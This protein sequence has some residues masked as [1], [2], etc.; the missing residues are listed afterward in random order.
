MAG[1]VP[2]VA[3]RAA[4][5]LIAPVGRLANLVTGWLMVLLARLGPVRRQRLAKGVARL[6]YGLGIRRRVT[7]DNLRQAF[8]EKDGTE[9]ERIARG[10]YA[11]MAITV[12]EAIAAS[13]PDG[14]VATAEVPVVTENWGLVEEAIA[15]KQGFLVA[16][17]HFGNWELLGEIMARRGIPIN[18]VVR[19]L[20]GALNARIVESR[21]K[22]GLKLI[23]QRGALPKMLKALREG[24]V[25]AQLIDQVL[26]AEHGVFVPFFGRP[27]CTTPAVS[28]A[29]LRT[30]APVFVALAARE[31]GHLRLFIEGPIPLPSTGDRQQDV[32]Q[33]T[34]LLTG[35]IE[36]Y[37][38]R[39]PEQW[40]WLH[41]R[42]KVQP[43]V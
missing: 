30:G 14:P 43:K 6:A 13:S 34:A 37:I 19:P 22:S 7:L 18:A 31:E 9:L 8:P 24:E 4:R 23:L 21:Q 29:A 10:A 39:Y 16:T 28:L 36:R 5:P 35:I 33:H 15:S 3:A 27:A 2:S 12:L 40:L 41:R 17:A 11:N 20:A 25:V 42:W 32:A 1:D 26:P 38:R